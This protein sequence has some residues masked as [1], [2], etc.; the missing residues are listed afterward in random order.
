MLKASPKSP[1]V[2]VSL[3]SPKQTFEIDAARRFHSGR[4]CLALALEN[5]TPNGNYSSIFLRHLD[6]RCA[7]AC[8]ASE[9]KMNVVNL[10][11]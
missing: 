1:Q 10:R 4:R 7:L 8:T 9:R 3:H 2:V 6:D 5:W 11:L